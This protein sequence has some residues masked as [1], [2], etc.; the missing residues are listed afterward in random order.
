MGVVEVPYFSFLQGVNV[1][2]HLFS[3]VNKEMTGAFISS[4]AGTSCR[5]WTF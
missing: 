2:D 4:R 5:L 3:Y 1:G